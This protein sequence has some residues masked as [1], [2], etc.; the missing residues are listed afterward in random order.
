MIRYEAN[1]FG[2]VVPIY[3]GRASN[4]TTDRRSLTEYEE[5]LLAE[6]KELKE[7]IERLE[8]DSKS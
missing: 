2:E 3:D 4:S 1:E 5:Q 6:I 7:E 8:Y